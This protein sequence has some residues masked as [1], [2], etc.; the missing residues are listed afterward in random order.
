[1]GKRKAVHVNRLSKLNPNSAKKRKKEPLKFG[2]DLPETASKSKVPTATKSEE[3]PWEGFRFINTAC[4]EKG[5]LAACACSNC[6]R[7]GTLSFS[8]IGVCGLAS[9]IVIKC[10]FAGCRQETQMETSPKVS[11]GSRGRKPYEINMRYVFGLRSVG[12]GKEGGSSLC[13]SLNVP[14]PPSKFSRYNKVFLKAVKGAAEQSMKAAAAEALAADQEGRRE[15]AGRAIEIARD[16]K[17]QAAEA[18]QKATAAAK[19]RLPNARELYNAAERLEKQSQTSMQHAR[20]LEAI[21]KNNDKDIAASFDGSFHTRG[22]SSKHGFA[23]AISVETGKVVDVQCQSKYC[24]ACTNMK[25]KKGTAEWDK[26]QKDHQCEITHESSSGAMEVESV[27]QMFQRSEKDRGVIYSHYL[28]DGDCKGHLAVTKADPYKG[29]KVEKLECINH[30]AKRMGTRLRNLVTKNRYTKCKD[31]KSLGGKGRLTEKLINKLQGYYAQA[32]REI[33]AEEGTIEQKYQKLVKTIW[34]AYY[35]HS[36][37]DKNPHHHSCPP[38][39]LVNPSWC[40]YNQSLVTKVPYT[41]KELLPSAVAQELQ[42]VYTDLTK[43]DLLIR[44]LHGK[45]QNTN[46]SMNQLPWK[47]ARKTEWCGYG[48]IQL[49]VYQSVL[50][51]NEGAA[52]QSRVFQLLN[53]EEGFY[54]RERALQ[55]DRD[56]EMRSERKALFL[57]PEIRREAKLKKVLEAKQEKSYGSGKF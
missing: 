33:V 48:T 3:H 29:K 17:D 11:T 53:I 56:R 20:S 43:R 38:G 36:S 32:I 45:T 23:S 14:P 34:R 4:F 25:S 5:I 28:G 31:G 57:L 12:I 8:E 46:E 22:F 42:K 16:S 27:L 39:S 40:K 41:H 50:E 7:V 30:V 9:V 18:R 51:F 6:K 52:S 49:V 19:D 10:N 35:H 47:K 55:R 54:S 44:C 1:M 2:P 24:H 26:F 21:A 37:T 13:G 15:E